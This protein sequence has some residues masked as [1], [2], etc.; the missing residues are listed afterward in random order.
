MRLGPLVLRTVA[1]E[2]D[3]MTAH[4][5]TTI[6]ESSA[7]FMKQDQIDEIVACLPKGKTYF[8]YFAE[9][10]ALMLLEIEEKP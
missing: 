4:A 5:A 6:P 8:Y 1:S 9:K 10:Y 3:A 2:P 7:I